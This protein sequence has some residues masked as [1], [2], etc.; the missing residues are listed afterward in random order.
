M[1]REDR[2]V[3][4]AHPLTGVRVIELGTFIAGP[5]AGQQLGDLGAEVIKIE[6]PGIGDPMRRWRDLGKGD[7]WWPSIARNKKSVTLNLSHPRARDIVLK[8]ASSAQ[9]VLENFRP[10]TLEKWGIGPD[11]LLKVNPGLVITRVSGFGQTGP[12]SRQPGF[13]SIGEAMGGIRHLTGWPDRPST[14]VGISLG[15]QIASLFATIGTLGALRYAERTGRGQVVDVAIYE[16]VFALMESLVADYEVTG[17]IRGRTGP[18][19]PNVVPSNVYPTADGSEVLIAA[20]SD[21]IFERLVKAL[22]LD[23]LRDNAEVA[24]HTGRMKHAEHID[25]VIAAKT[26]TVTASDLLR[27]LEMADIPH[28]LIYTAKDIAEDEHYAARGAIR[29]FDIPGVGR[30]AMA[31]PTPRL[32]VSPGRIDS[33]GPALGQHTDEVLRNIVG[34]DPAEVD[35]LRAEG[36][37]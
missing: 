31:A 8:L 12:R 26:S 32:T 15:D 22:E 5:F 37:V 9:V 29:R 35:E 25:R 1:T 23:E 11:E 10:G 4:L 20:N 14:R 24:H 33:L 21:A 36:I 18:T 30:V 13:G 19:L 28:G 27:L 6:Q 17:Y 3:E 7:L 2:Q 34:L 16:A